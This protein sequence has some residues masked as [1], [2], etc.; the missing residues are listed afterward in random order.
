[1]SARNDIANAVE[2]YRERHL[3]LDRFEDQFRN[4]AQAIF[5]YPKDVQDAVVAIENLLSEYRAQFL[6]ANDLREGLAKAV[7]PFEPVQ[8]SAFAANDY[9]QHPSF[10]PLSGNSTHFNVAR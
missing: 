5:S 6:D 3:S 1:M 8:Q 2:A 4:I 10:F 7:R 9:G